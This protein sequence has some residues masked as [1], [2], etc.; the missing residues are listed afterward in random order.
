MRRRRAAD[1]DGGN[2]TH[3]G[4]GLPLLVVSDAEGNVFEIPELR[5]AGMAL[6]RPVLPDAED[7]IPLPDGSDLFQLPGRTAVGYD[8]ASGEFVEVDEYGGIP[9]WAVAAFMAPAYMQILGA[10]F[11]PEAQAPPLTL[12]SY[13]A[14]GWRQGGGAG[15]GAGTGRRGDGDGGGFAVCGVRIDA[16]RRQDPALMDEGAIRR[17]SERMLSRYPSNRLVSHLVENC[18]RRYGCPAARNFVQG[19]WECPVPTARGCNARCIGCLSCQTEEAGFPSSQD[20]IAFTPSVEEIVPFC[21]DHLESAPR[22]VISFGQGCEGEPLLEGDLIEEAIRRIRRRTDR[23]VI[24]VNTNGSRPDVVRRLCAAGLDSIR[25]SLSSAREPFY[26]AYFRP[27]GFGLEHALESLRIVRRAGLWSSVNYFVFPGFTDGHEETEALCR[28][29]TEARVNMVQTRNLNLDPDLY[30]D[31]LGL[32]APE[33]N[34]PG[35]RAWLE[36]IRRRCPWVRLG[37]FNPPREEMR[38]AHFRFP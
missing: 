24:N 8:P 3:G 16:D 11:R 13:T 2:G 6:R 4:A 35:M 32:N 1:A 30:V 25:V 14:V 36:T 5:M 21:A 15:G 29:L 10:A 18:V 37:Y 12:F 27:S 9:V 19:R 23:G 22:P 26:E 17:G 33:E 38:D 7:L 31:R 34:P 20:R 28:V